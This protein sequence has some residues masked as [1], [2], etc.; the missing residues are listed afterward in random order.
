V[1]EP[2][3]KVGQRIKYWYGNALYYSIIHDR[4]TQ[5][6]EWKYQVSFGW[7]DKLWID[8]YYDMQDASR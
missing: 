8:E 5:R 3:F 2:K 6:G 1:T 4:A 7:L